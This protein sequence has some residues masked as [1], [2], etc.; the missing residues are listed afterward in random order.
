GHVVLQVEGLSRK[1]VL[2]DINFSLNKGEVLGI[3]GLRGAGRTELVRAIFGADPIDS[4]KVTVN[5]RQV[6][7]NSP[8][9]AI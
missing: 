9:Q 8:R 6:K 4:G 3:A 7:I 2:H 5:G 1:G